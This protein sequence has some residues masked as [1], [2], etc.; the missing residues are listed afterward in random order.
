MAPKSSQ[1]MS[2]ATIIPFFDVGECILISSSPI[3]KHLDVTYYCSSYSLLTEN[4]HRARMRFTCSKNLLPSVLNAV[5]EK[6]RLLGDSDSF[7]D[8]LSWQPEAERIRKV[9]IQHSRRP[10]GIRKLYFWVR[11]VG[12]PASAGLLLCTME[13]AARCCGCMGNCSSSTQVQAYLC[14]QPMVLVNSPAP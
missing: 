9:H 8:E 11:W 14:L 13:E 6:E 10:G 7:P 5:R 3:Q 12:R 4:H 1:V 2:A